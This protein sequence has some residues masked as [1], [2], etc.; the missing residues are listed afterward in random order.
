MTGAAGHSGVVSPPGMRRYVAGFVCG[1]L[2]GACGSIP[3][4][5]PFTTGLLMV[6]S[7][8]RAPSSFRAELFSGEQGIRADLPQGSLEL[9]FRD[10]RR[11]EYRLIVRNASTT[12]FSSLV[13]VV[14]PGREVV[15][16]SELE[17]R[18]SYVQVR[19]TGSLAGDEP[20]VGVLESLRRA[21]GRFEV[22][23]LPDAGSGSLR[24]VLNAN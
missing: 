22:R 11:F 13:L 3:R 1:I 12:T 18:G 24:G 23:L 16:A 20:G 8:T 4:P 10:S 21:G 17:L 2:L 5:A 19:G 6:P 7:G 9:D 14:S 15:L